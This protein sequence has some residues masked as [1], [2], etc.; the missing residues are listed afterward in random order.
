MSSPCTYVVYPLRSDSIFSYN[1]PASVV[2]RLQYT[3]KSFV[4][5]YPILM[6]HSVI[7]NCCR[8]CAIYSRK[9]KTELKELCEQTVERNQVEIQLREALYTRASK[10]LFSSSTIS[11]ELTSFHYKFTRMVI[12]EPKR[13]FAS[14]YVQPGIVHIRV[15]MRKTEESHFRYVVYFHVVVS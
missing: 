1:K 6:E 13:S 12:Y 14:V 5:Q 4:N 11:M 10:I 15:C 8:C 9:H 3:S 2:Y 7:A